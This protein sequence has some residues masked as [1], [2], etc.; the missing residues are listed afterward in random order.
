MRVKQPRERK[1]RI[2]LPEYIDIQLPKHLSKEKQKE[3][4]DKHAREA[5][6]GIRVTGQHHGYGLHFPATWNSMPPWRLL[7]AKWSRT[8]AYHDDL[9]A[10]LLGNPRAKA[11]HITPE[12]KRHALKRALG[13][14]S[15]CRRLW[16]RIKPPRHRTK[17]WDFHHKLAIKNG[18]KTKKGNILAVCFDCHKAIHGRRAAR[19]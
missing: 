2:Y 3:L 12:I 19:D 4:A 5:I 7:P 8:Y 13:R 6:R 15:E 16:R 17:L 11:G 14:C 1:V 18:G 10:W 9:E